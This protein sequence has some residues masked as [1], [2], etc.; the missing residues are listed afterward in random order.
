MSIKEK[1]T[2]IYNKIYTGQMMEA[3]EEYYAEE[4]V[5]QENE[6]EPRVGKAVNREWE[7]NF[8]ANVQEWHGGAVNAICVNEE[9]GVAMVESWVEITFKGAPLRPASN[10]SPVNNGGMGR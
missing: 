5:M 7:K 4:V 2:D 8:L 10:K 6:E 1:V 3:F 9:E